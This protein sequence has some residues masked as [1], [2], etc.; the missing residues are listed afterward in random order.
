MEQRVWA[1]TVW[2]RCTIWQETEI[3]REEL[4]KEEASNI[5]KDPKTKLCEVYLNRQQH[6]NLKHEHYK[7]G[8]IKFRAINIQFLRSIVWQIEKDIIK[9]EKV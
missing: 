6:V 9:N 5:R 8:E 3:W 7:E 4:F 1:G 2:G